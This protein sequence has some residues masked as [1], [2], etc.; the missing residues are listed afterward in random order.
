MVLSRNS[1]DPGVTPSLQPPGQE[2]FVWRLMFASGL[3]SKS[4]AQEI[5]GESTALKRVLSLVRKAAQTDSA[6]LICG[7]P[8]S[9]KE[10]VA[11]AIHRLGPR[12]NGSFVKVSAATVGE[13]LLEK[14]LFGFERGAFTG[15]VNSNAGRFS[16]ADRGTLFLDEICDMPLEV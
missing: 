11:R 7:E 13:G 12:R 1:P 14:E 4:D 5:V 2:S 15:A 16:I 9:G 8:G 10:L 6:A 3:D